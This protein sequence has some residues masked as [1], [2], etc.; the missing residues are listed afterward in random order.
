M[1]APLD[2][3]VASLVATT[4]EL[5]AIPAPTGDEGTRADEVDRRLRALGLTPERDPVGNVVARMPL[6]GGRPA[7]P[8][9]PA[10]VVSAHLDT[11]FGREVALEPR[12]DGDRLLGPG[13][14]DDT[15]AL[16]ALLTLAED[17]VAEPPPTA[18]VLAAT[19]G[20]EGLGDLRGAKHLLR[21][22]PTR[23]FVAVEGHLLDDLVVGGI[24]A[25]RLQ[26]SYRGPGGHSWGDRGTAS[27]A[28]ALLA[29]G[30]AALRAV[31]AGRHVNVGVVEAGT[32]VNAIA[33]EARLLVDLRDEDD[34]RLR[35]TATL[36]RRALEAAPRGIHATV[37]QVG[38]RPA[39]R[40]PHDHPLVRA[41]RE[42]RAAV[43]L[44][45]AR[46]DAG[47]TECNAAFPLAIPTV[48]VGITHGGDMH[49]TSEW[50]AIPPIARGLASLR[51]LVRRA[52]AE[53]SGV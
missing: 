39:G 40:T 50:V 7:D 21:H 47:S 33:A 38:H 4:L 12:R 19:V 49:R 13:I 3:S 26:A 51:A 9:A 52:A 53:G 18:V 48:C 35:R 8:D 46:E 15:V 23:A 24:G 20:E 28:H 37:E 25:L 27:A 45:P 43:G 32:T 10:L 42:A 34:Q 1:L 44:P 16:A 14:G 5:A 6:A 31:P 41:A 11:V 22:V 30:A 2:P 29:A 17:L 36:V